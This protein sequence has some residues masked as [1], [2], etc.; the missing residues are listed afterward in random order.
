M[1]CVR[2]VR[3]TQA[4]PIETLVAPKSKALYNNDT[5]DP[6]TRAPN[7]AKDENR[8]ALANDNQSHEFP[9]LPNQQE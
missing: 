2:V 3:A 4:Q 8:H 5:L 1:N 9:Y 7:I 6:S